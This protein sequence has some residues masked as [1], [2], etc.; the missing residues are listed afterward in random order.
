MRAYE[1]LLHYVTFHTKSDAE[2]TSSPSSDNQFV[3]ARALVEELKS[4]GV[5][6][7][8]CDEYCYVYGHVPAT[9]GYEDATPIGLIA[10]MDTADFNDL[11]VNAQLHENYDGG[12]IALGESGLV[13]SPEAFPHLKNRIGQTLITTD[14]TTILGADDKAGIAE[15]MT[16]VELADT[17]NHGPICVGFTPDE[18]IG[19]ICENFDIEHFG[20]KYAYTLDGEL[21]NEVETHTFNAASAKINFIGENNHPGSAKNVMVNAALLAMEF[22]GLLPNAERPEYTEGF[23]GFF[24]LLSMSGDVGEA[25]LSYLIR[26]FDTARFEARKDIMR[27]I[28]KYMNEKYGKERVI[29]ELKDQCYNMHNILKDYPETIDN[30]VQAS[31]NAGLDPVIVPMRGGTDGAALCFRGLPCPNLGTGASQLHG[32]YEHITCEAMDKAVNVLIELLKLFAE[33]Q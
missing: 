26:D 10:H 14:G 7:A 2:S 6:D 11:P 18:E 4:L 31:K 33:N 22:D 3:L 17:F 16:V 12:E 8:V 13:L 21:E 30:A 1:R 5:E 27:Q 29:C 25:Q 9:P 19:R 23:E 28:T 24:H 15:I 32:P 20:A